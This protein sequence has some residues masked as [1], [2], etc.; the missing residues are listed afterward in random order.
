MALD[1]PGCDSQE[2][3]NFPI[4]KADK[5]LQLDQFGFGGLDGG[6]PVQRL[7]QLEQVILGNWAGDLDIIEVYPLESAAVTLTGARVLGEAVPAAN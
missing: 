1:G 6:E 3:R 5:E 7:V 4:L 2:F